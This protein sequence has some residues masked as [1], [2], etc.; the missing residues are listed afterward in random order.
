[1][2]RLLPSSGQHIKTPKIT[3][4]YTFYAGYY[5]FEYLILE[6]RIGIPLLTK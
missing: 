4:D 2:F 5:D 6:P 1:M 3:L